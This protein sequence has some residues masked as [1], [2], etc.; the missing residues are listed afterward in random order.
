MR[1]I[2]LVFRNLPVE[3]IALFP[4]IVFR[5]SPTPGMDGLVN[6]ERIHLRQQLELLILPFYIWYLLAYMF[7]RIKGMNHGSAYRSIVF[8]REAYNH[9]ADPDYLK[10]RPI[11]AFL[12]E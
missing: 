3:G 11:W 2:Y 8:E 9:D 4:F 5:T 7:Y 12:R 6:H 10:N 1:P